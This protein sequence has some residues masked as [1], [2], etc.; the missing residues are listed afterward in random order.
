MSPF[1]DGISARA[2]RTLEREDR[3]VWLQLGIQEKKTKKVARRNTETMRE[4]NEKA[5]IANKGESNMGFLEILFSHHAI[6]NDF[7]IFWK[8]FS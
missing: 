1:L 3:K 7:K 6:E 2:Q 4:K 8:Y 5:K